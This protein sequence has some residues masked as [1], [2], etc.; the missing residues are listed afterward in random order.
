MA[1]EFRTVTFKVD[2]VP[3]AAPTEVMENFYLKG[4]VRRIDGRPV[5][6]VALQ[7]F[8]VEVLENGNPSHTFMSLDKVSVESVTPASSEYDGCIKLTIWRRNHPDTS[9]LVNWRFKYTVTAL[10]IADIVSA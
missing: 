6:N 7:S 5:M 10:V 8:S 1:I 2:S 9:K 4:K 3:M